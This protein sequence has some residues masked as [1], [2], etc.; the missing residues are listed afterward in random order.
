MT[1][2]A[3]LKEKDYQMILNIFKEVRLKS[4]SIYEKYF[5]LGA[6]CA[7]NSHFG[8]KDLGKNKLNQLLALVQP[9]FERSRRGQYYSYLAEKR[10]FE[11]GLL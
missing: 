5:G 11:D 4:R 8:S 10:S 7:R 6:S 3:C 2:G 9:R 1:L